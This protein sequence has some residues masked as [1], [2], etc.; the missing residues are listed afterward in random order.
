MGASDEHHANGES[1]VLHEGHGERGPAS[2]GTNTVEVGLVG[3]RRA[4]TSPS[5]VKLFGWS[6]RRSDQDV[7]AAE[8]FVE[9]VDEGPLADLAAYGRLAP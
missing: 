3:E 7:A 6:I 2:E 1:I 9:V 4:T 5:Q 8:R